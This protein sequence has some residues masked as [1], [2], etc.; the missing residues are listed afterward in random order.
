MSAEPDAVAPAAP[1]VGDVPPD[2]TLPDQY[3]R[4]VSA[5]TWRGDRNVV[6]VFYPFAFTGICT[7]ELREIRD[8]LEDFQHDGI[9]VLA[10]SCDPVPALRAWAD[11][12]GYFFPLLS[13]FWP[14][15]EVSRALGVFDADGGF[16]RVAGCPPDYFSETGQLWGNPLYDWDALKKTE[17]AWWIRRI[18]HQISLCDYLRVDHFRAFE[19]YYAIPADAKTAATGATKKATKKS[20]TTLPA[21]KAR[22]QPAKK[23][24]SKRTMKPSA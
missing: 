17:Y 1:E 16:A 22:P 9:Q 5:A 21:K 12:E 15:G 13:D 20:A 10:I 18:A 14:H 8:T 4:Q 23:R 11:Q 19:S 24:A 6:L 7:G 2:F 3:G